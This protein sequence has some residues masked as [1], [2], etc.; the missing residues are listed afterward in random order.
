MILID[1]REGSKE[2]ADP[3]SRMGLPV[4]L[5]RMEYGDVAF[6]GRGPEEDLGI[7]IEYKSV[8]DL[9]QSWHDGRL[10]GH[11][12]P[13]ML[14][15]YSISYLLVEG[16]VSADTDDSIRI[17]SRRNRWELA[18][19][20]TKFSNL[21]GYLETLSQCYGVKILQSTTLLASAV[22]VASIY[23]WWQKD[24]HTHGTAV[25]I[26]TAPGLRRGLI[27]PTRIMKVASTFPGVGSEKLL[28]I[29]AKF[30]SIKQMVNADAETWR[31]ID[32]IGR[33]VSENIVNYMEEK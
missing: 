32:G 8:S 6:I 33:K 1:P 16:A 2:L 14:Q 22:M 24:Y 13:G 17:L 26:H 3:L 20:Q 30:D 10:L 15:S 12:L 19:S 27:M 4:R 31:T 9:L 18:R 25:T 23:R 21:V 11:Q 28:D 29:E 7:G 5:E